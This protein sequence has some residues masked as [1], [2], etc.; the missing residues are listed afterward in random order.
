ML[1]TCQYCLP[2]RRSL[3][4]EFLQ[5]CSLTAL[6]RLVERDALIEPCLRSRPSSFP[7]DAFEIPAPAIA[8]NDVFVCFRR[9]PT[10]HRVARHYTQGARADL[11]P[12]PQNRPVRSE[13]RRAA[14]KLTN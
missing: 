11:P 5:G 13:E 4:E 8:R 14:K 3:A 12:L 10:A 7:F 6:A 2:T 1:S 9:V